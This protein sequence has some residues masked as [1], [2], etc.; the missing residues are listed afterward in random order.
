[1]EREDTTPGQGI[2]LQKS[3]IGDFMNSLDTYVSRA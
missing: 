1:M 2:Y 3:I